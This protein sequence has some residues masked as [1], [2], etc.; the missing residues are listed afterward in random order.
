[1]KHMSYSS[2]NTCNNC[3]TPSHNAGHVLYIT[4]SKKKS[5]IQQK[6]SNIDC[7]ETNFYTIYRY[8]DNIL[9]YAKTPCH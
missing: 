5:S 2:H 6:A 8:M 4:D 7:I 9:S 1:M 3:T